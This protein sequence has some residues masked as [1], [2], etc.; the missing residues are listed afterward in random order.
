MGLSRA[1]QIRAGYPADMIAVAGD[2]V[3]DA[4]ALRQVR[5]VLKAGRVIRRAGE[6]RA[7]AV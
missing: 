2:P 5:L 7:A 1:G 6:W 4:R 3:D